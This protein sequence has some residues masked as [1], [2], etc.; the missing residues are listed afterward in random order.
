MRV[1]ADKARSIIAAE[2]SDA[3]VPLQRHEF[4]SHDLPWSCGPYVDVVQQTEI[5]SDIRVPRIVVDERT[6]PVYDRLSLVDLDPEHVMR[7]AAVN[8]I[9]AALD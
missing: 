9:H 3:H 6:S 5:V 2:V 4:Q 1:P 8:C 7:T